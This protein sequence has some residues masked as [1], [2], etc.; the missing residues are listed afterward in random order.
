MIQYISPEMHK[1]QQ[2]GCP[3]NDGGSCLEQVPLEECSHLITLFDS[4]KDKTSESEGAVAIQDESANTTVGTRQVKEQLGIP[5]YSGYAFSNEQADAMAAERECTTVIITGDVDS[6]KTTLVGRSYSAFLKG[7]VGDWRFAGTR[8]LL[9]YDQRVH[10]HRKSSRRAFATTHHTP[11]GVY[12]YFHL[13]I[14]S[15]TE[16][17]TRTLLIHDISGENYQDAI[18][19]SAEAESLGMLERA[20]VVVVMMNGQH[21]LLKARRVEAV[22]R[23]KD[24][25]QA[26]GNA[27]LLAKAPPI[28]I[29]V[30]R[31][32]Y[33]V[34]AGKVEESYALMELIYVEIENAL[35]EVG[36][37]SVVSIH[38]V[39]SVTHNKFPA[40]YGFTSLFETWASFRPKPALVPSENL[41]YVGKQ[42]G[43][44]ALASTHQRVKDDNE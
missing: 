32:D 11:R 28:Q 37:A 27:R 17:S 21:L 6:G 24:I 9:G 10:D 35:R 16:G 18:S 31:W 39:A 4:E 44:T 42:E 15:M 5:I 33:I 19:R 7:P 25:L 41:P 26:V 13:D 36:V 22:S 3:F 14:Q 34:E 40:G 43:W 12:E 1:C 29:V 30:S 38:E 8:T 20:D 23:M 2:E